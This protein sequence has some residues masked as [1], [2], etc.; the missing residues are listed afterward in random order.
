MKF[1]I[2]KNDTGETVEVIEAD[3]AVIKD[4]LYNFYKDDKDECKASHRIASFSQ[5]HYSFFEVKQK[6]KR[7]AMSDIFDKDLIDFISRLKK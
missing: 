7:I 2:I 1:K 4:N 3:M 6:S 5:S